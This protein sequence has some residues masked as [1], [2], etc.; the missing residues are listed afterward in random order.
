MKSDN[1]KRTNYFLN[2]KFI[3]KA[4]LGYVAYIAIFPSFLPA[5]IH[6][7]RGAK[8][9]N[10]FKV[11]IAPQVMIDSLYPELITIQEGVYITRGVSIISHFN[12]TNAIAN[13]MKTDTVLKNVVI[14]KDSFIGI[15]SIILPGVNIGKCCIISAG[16]VVTSNVP[17]FTVVQG[18]PSKKIGRLPKSLIESYQKSE[19]FLE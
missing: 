15:N 9:S 17:D 1:I 6:K 3:A 19:N 4:F 12:P 16:S 18:N 5:L 7:L 8:I 2:L 13:L 14:G 11:Y 10:P